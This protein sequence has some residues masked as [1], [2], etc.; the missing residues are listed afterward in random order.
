MS[1]T[2]ILLWGLLATATRT[3][4]EVAA[5]GLGLSRMSIPFFLGTLFTAH[6]D[7][8]TVIGFAVDFLVGWGFAGLYALVFT[9]LGRA[10]L[11]LGV[12]LGAGHG[13]FLLL[14]G[15]QVLCAVHPRM[16]S[17]RTGPSPKRILEPPGPLALNYGR[18]TPASTLFAHLVYGAMLGVLYRV[19]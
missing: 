10:T 8:A 6:R 4:I 13:L 2:S 5:Q 9:E 1:L 16:A 15:M 12:A 19:P 14:V 17:E 3:S 18:W 11:L 7:R